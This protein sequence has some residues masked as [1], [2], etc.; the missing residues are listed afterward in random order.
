MVLRKY[1]TSSRIRNIYT[2]GLERTV[3]ID[4]DTMSEENELQNILLL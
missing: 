1:L 2:N 4:F 3:F